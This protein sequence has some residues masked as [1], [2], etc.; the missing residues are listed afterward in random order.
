MMRARPTMFALLTLGLLLAG[1][2]LSLANTITS[3]S[4]IRSGPISTL[5]PKS[6]LA[7]S[8]QYCVAFCSDRYGDEHASCMRTCLARRENCN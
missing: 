7:C 6:L 2:D 3:K 5:I 1:L 4:T 8:Q